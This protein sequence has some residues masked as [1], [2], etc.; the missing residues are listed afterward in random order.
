[1]TERSSPRR[2][3]TDEEEEALIKRQLVSLLLS[4]ESKEYLRNRRENELIRTPPSASPTNSELPQI[5]NSSETPRRVIQARGNLRLLNEI[6]PPSKSGLKNSLLRTTKDDRG[7]A[8][9]RSEDGFRAERWNILQEGESNDDL[10]MEGEAAVILR[11]FD[12]RRDEFI[13][14]AMKD[15]RLS[16]KRKNKLLQSAVNNSL[17]RLEDLE[18]MMRECEQ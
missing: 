11:R 6:E 7:T 4:S 14:K 2:V 15:P 18:R 8:D 1:M 13:E 12:I 16:Q 9:I 17:E 3:G 5:Q 10:D